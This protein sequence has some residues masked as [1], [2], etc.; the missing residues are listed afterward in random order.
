VSITFLNIII[1]L[2]SVLALPKCIQGIVDTQ[3]SLWTAMSYFRSLPGGLPQTIQDAIPYCMGV[4][5]GPC[6]WSCDGQCLYNQDS[7]QPL[8]LRASGF[9]LSVESF[10]SASISIYWQLHIIYSTQSLGK[11]ISTAVLVALR[12]LGCEVVFLEVLHSGNC[13]TLEVL[14]ANETSEVRVVICRWNFCPQGYLYKCS[15]LL[16]IA[17]SS[18]WV[19][20]EFP[21]VLFRVLL[22]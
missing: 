5:L 15:S 12:V 2:K 6:T 16:I 18:H 9:Q 7:A 1:R 11:R 13:L 10:T 19:K 20:Y 3:A 22:G 21:S 4:L 17:S 14:K 8:F